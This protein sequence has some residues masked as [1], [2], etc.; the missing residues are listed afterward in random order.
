[1]VLK[2]FTLRG[3]ASRRTGIMSFRSRNQRGR[4]GLLEQ[5]SLALDGPRLVLFASGYDRRKEAAVMHRR[6]Q[7][8]ER[9]EMLRHAVALVRL[10]AIA[11]AFLRQ[12][13]RQTITCHLGDDGGGGNRYDD[14][15]A[16]DHGVAVAG[17]IEPVAAVDEDVLRRFRQTLDRAFERP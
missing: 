6:T 2:C 12:R 7:P 5:I 13:A 10:K 16:A 11:R 15:V 14:A 3:N 4:F 17:R 9:L 8:V 1:M